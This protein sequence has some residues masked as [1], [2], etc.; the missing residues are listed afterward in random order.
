METSFLEVLAKGIPESLLLVLCVYFFCK[1]K[2]KGK[3]LLVILLIHVVITYLA[4]L[5][6][7]SYGMTLLINVVILVIIFNTFLK[8][9]MAKVI[10]GALLGILFIIIA[11]AFNFL[12]IQ[13]FFRDK[14]ETILSDPNLRVIYTIPSTITFGILVFAVYYLNFIKKSK[15]DVN[16]EENISDAKDVKE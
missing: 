4:R 9:P 16:D 3:Q 7:P 5:Y 6:L 14:L 13:Y 11:E 15:K 12:I 1:I 10:N 8:V 2:P